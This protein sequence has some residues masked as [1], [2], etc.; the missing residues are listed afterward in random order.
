M[1]VFPEPGGP[2]DDVPEHLYHADQTA[3]SSSGARTLIMSC[4]AKYRHQREHGRPD[5]AA[6]EFGRAYHA[7]ILG[8]GP[9]VAE[10]DATTW[11]TKAA[12]EAAE[13][14]RA[15]GRIP[16]LAKD[17]ERLHDMAWALAQHPVAAPLFARPGKAEQTFVAPD[18]DT[19]VMCRIR[20]DWMPDVP[21]DARVIVCDLKTTSNAEP[22]AFARSMANYGYHQQGAFYCDVLGWAGHDHGRPPRF[23]LVAQ[24]KEPP[25]LVTIAEPDEQAIE[26]GRELNR[27]ALRLYRRCTDTGV[28]PGY[29]HGPTGIAVL[30]LP[31]WQVAAYEAAADRREPIGETA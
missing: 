2:Y 9:A 30:R 7:L 14:A 4:P 25:H 24:E 20:V 5:T 1:S 31:G 19:G 16:L 13:K 8:A 27:E 11:R 28:W 6:M 29:D 23:V 15:E 12:T 22:I 26:W 18:P 10:I 17:A 21:D 3:L